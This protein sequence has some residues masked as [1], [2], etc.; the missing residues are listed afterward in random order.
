MSD[1]GRQPERRRRNVVAFMPL[2]GFLALAGVFLYQ[3]ASGRDASE[4]PSV[5]I[6]TKA[7]TLAL[8]PLE[9]LIADGAAVPALTDAAISGKLAVIN[10]FASWC[11]P[12]RQEHPLLMEL[13][14]DPRIILVG[15]N[16]KDDPE[17]A[18]RFLG[19]LGNPY[20]AVGVDP[21]GR[22]SIDWG[23]YGVPETFLVARDGTILYKQIGPFTLDTFQNGLMPIIT[24]HAGSGS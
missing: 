19:E 18:L 14:K 1:A 5:L 9:G 7:P 3:L 10:F 8:P 15:V 4:I 6:G 22:T 12:C 13:A 17:N 16:H 11:V 20:A 21:E 2:A 24:E 23:A